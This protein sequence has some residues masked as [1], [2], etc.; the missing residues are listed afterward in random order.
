MIFQNSIRS[1]ELFKKR[2]AQHA[3]GIHNVY[4]IK[5]VILVFA[6]ALISMSSTLYAQCVRSKQLDKYSTVLPTG[7]NFL[8]SFEVKDVNS[9]IGKVE[10]SYPFTKDT[11]YIVNIYSDEV[12]SEGIK[13]T[14]Y[15]SDRR[16]LVSS[17]INDQYLS[18]II[19][20]CK[21]TGIYYITYTFENAMN[22]C[23]ESV[24]GFKK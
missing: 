12:S 15:D 16:K 21:K 19:F 22:F 24:V 23:G 9:S 20:N 17:N 13:I 7:Y 5:Y 10:Y 2:I 4:A 14:L 6:V 18:P 1:N 11:Q 8:K 3:S